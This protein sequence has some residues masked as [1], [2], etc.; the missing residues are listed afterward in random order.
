MGDIMQNLF[1]EIVMPVLGTAIAALA[2]WG[3]G[4]L[5]T[6]LDKKTKFMDADEDRKQKEF[7]K[8]QVLDAVETAVLKTNQKL[9]KG[10][11]KAKMDGHL[12]TDEAKQALSEA[13]KTAGSLLT[14]D[15]KNIAEGMY[16]KAFNE[17]IEDKI[18]QVLS[19]SKA[20]GK[21]SAP[22]VPG[23]APKQG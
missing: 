5:I 23:E 20:S 12:T 1:I 7:V 21:I 15:A 4:K 14:Q 9:V 2:T 18:E 16:G 6:F 11:K 19:L 3:V 22:I 13:A 10:L 17:L 8:A